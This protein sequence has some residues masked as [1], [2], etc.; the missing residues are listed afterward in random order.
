MAYKLFELKYNGEH[1]WISALTNI[2]ALKTWSETTDCS[3]IELDDTDEIIEIPES[4]WASLT[5]TNTDRDIDDQDD[6]ETQTLEQYMKTVSF[7]QII[8]GSAYD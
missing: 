2:E 3:L 7:S 1:E 5:I 4:Q 6:W 8:G